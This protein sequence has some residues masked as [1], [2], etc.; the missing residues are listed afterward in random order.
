MMS[1]KPLVTIA[2][3]TYNRAGSYLRTALESALQQTYEHTEVVVIDNASTDHTPDL[4]GSY[5]EV[6]P[7]LRYIRRSANQGPVDNFQRCLDAA[8][9]DFFLMLHDDDRLDP[10]FLSTC[11]KAADYDTD[12]GYVRTGIRCIDAQ[13]NLVQEYPN[14]AGDLQHEAYINAWLQY[15]VYWYFASSLLNTELFRSIGGFITEIEQ[16]VDTATFVRF[17]FESRGVNV[18]PI[19]ASLREHDDRITTHANIAEWVEEYQ[20]VKELIVDRSAR[21]WAPTLASRADEFSGWLLC[22]W[23]DDIP[24]K[25]WRLHVYILIARAFGLRS[26]PRP[27]SKVVRCIAPS[28]VERYL[29]QRLRSWRRAGDA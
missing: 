7:Q 17:A 6:Y 22:H 28:P 8:E 12:I 15:K 20:K 26:I 2:I 19:K 14:E 13:G 4:V 10:D 21:E 5:G 11:L 18:R 25:L 23:A 24:N 16:V 9:G 29:E 3:P 1:M 27:V